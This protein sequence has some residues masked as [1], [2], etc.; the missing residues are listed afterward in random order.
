MPVQQD[1]EYERQLVS[2]AVDDPAA[3]QELYEGYLQ[4]VY[5]YVAARVENRQDAEDIVANVFLSIIRHRLQFRNQRASSFAAW[6]FTIA[7]NAVNDF[8]RQGLANTTVPLD[9]LH[10]A[11]AAETPHETALTEQETARE[12]RRRINA[13]PERRRDIIM[14]RFFAGLRNQEIASVLGLDE[15]TVASHLSR[16][17]RDLY[18]SYQPAELQPERFSHDAK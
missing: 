15:R 18:Q 17:L 9:D 2:R 14:L 7:R 11:P 1:P 10:D 12:L 16:A 8:Y 13:L 3:F 5:G 6:V 4:R